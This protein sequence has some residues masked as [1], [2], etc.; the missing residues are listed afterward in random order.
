ME[1]NSHKVLHVIKKCYFCIR[2]RKGSTVLYH[3]KHRRT[4]GSGSKEKRIFFGKRLH[5]T[6]RWLPLP[7]RT[8]GFGCETEAEKKVQKTLKKSWSERK[9]AYLCSPDSKEW[10]GLHS[11]T[12]TDEGAPSGATTIHRA[13]PGGGMNGP[14]VL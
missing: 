7:P 9:D 3:V 2:F 14:N 11:K 5:G 1:K 10:W 8:E 4:A 12:D 13:A 6:K